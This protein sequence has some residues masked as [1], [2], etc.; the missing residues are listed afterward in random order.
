MK[1][2]FTLEYWLDDGWY[3][4][5]LREIPGVFSQAESLPELE[6]NIRDAYNLMLIENALP[7]VKIQTKTIEMT[8]TEEKPENRK[9]D[10]FFE[11]A[12]KVE[13]D[14]EAVRKLREISKL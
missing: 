13:I 2:L 5:R 3:V 12:R 10:N 11:A 8:I 4:G 14:E 6:D 1:K 9:M 7:D